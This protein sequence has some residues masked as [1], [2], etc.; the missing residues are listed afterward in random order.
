MPEGTQLT[1]RPDSLPA[2]DSLPANEKK[3][4]A[5]MMEVFAAFTAHTDYEVGRLIDTIDCGAG[6]PWAI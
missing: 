3:V 2:W 4:Y 6:A 5:R 1:E